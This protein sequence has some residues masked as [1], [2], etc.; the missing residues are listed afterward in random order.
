MTG[1]VA[2]DN[3]VD[4]LLAKA[5]AAIDNAE[6]AY[7]ATEA[8]ALGTAYTTLAGVYIAGQ[9]VKAALTELARDDF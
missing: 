9:S 6:G 8:A 5:E 2:I 1:S 4:D 7:S 3:R